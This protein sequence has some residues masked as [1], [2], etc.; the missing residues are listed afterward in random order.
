M[1]NITSD[2][3]RVR[4]DLQNNTVCVEFVMETEQGENRTIVYNIPEEYRTNCYPNSQHPHDIE[5]ELPFT[6]AR[7]QWLSDILSSEI[8]ERYAIELWDS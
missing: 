2:I 5:K 6:L 7:A 4:R 1:K 8:Y 3:K